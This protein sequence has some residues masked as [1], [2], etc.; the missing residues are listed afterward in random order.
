MNY[1]IEQKEAF[2]M[3]GI[4]TDINAADNRPYVEIPVFWKKCMADGTIDCIYLGSILNG[5]MHRRRW[6][7]KDL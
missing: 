3:F 1:R 6:N 4:S 5:R 2:E 7:Q